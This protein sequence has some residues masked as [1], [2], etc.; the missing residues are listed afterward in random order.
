MNMNWMR[1]RST[2]ALAAVKEKNWFNA[3]NVSI[4]L[5]IISICK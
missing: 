1:M 2:E 5:E 3:N 4:G